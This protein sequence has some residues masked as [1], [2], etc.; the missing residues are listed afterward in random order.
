[1]MLEVF[2]SLKSKG[3]TIV[4]SGHQLEL[5]ERLDDRVFLHHK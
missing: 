4:L 3:T 2:R 1:M 5:V